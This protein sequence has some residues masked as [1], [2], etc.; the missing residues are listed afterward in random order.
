MPLLHICR[1]HSY[2]RILILCGVLALGATSQADEVAELCAIL[3]SDAPL[4]DRGVACRRLAVIGSTES[5]PVLATWL[6]DAELSHLARAALEAIPSPQVDSLFRQQ[7]STASGDQLIGIIDSIGN[8][9]DAAAVESLALL[10]PQSAGA[11]QAAV[12]A[13]LGAIASPES[14]EILLTLLENRANLQGDAAADATVVNAVADAA[15]RCADRFAVEGKTVEALQVYDAVRAAPV[16]PTLLAAATLSTIRIPGSKG[17]T[18]LNEQLVS[19][20]DDHFAVGLQA[21]RRMRASDVVG[22][23]ADALPNATPQ[24]AVMLLDALSDLGDTSALPAVREAA[25]SEN[26]GVKA[27]AIS[28]LGKV[29]DTSVLELLLAASGSDNA[30]VASAAQRSLAE[31]HGEGV[32]QAIL[33][34]LQRTPAHQETLLRLIGARR[35]KALPVLWAAMKT[36]ELPV[37]MAA[38]DALGRTI[39]DADILPLVDVVLNTTGEEHAAA[40]AALTSACRRASDPDETVRQISARFAAAPLDLQRMRFDILKTIGGEEAL[41]QV[42]RGAMDPEEPIQDAATRALGEWPTPDVGPELLPLCHLLQI[43][44]FKIR[45]LR[46]YIR[47]FKQF[48]LPSEERL[49]MAREAFAL[50]TR[51]EDKVLILHALLSFQNRESMQFALEHIKDPGLEA[52]A[53]QVAIYISEQ[54][55]DKQAVIDAMRSILDS[56]AEETYAKQARDILAKNGALGQ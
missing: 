53:A 34:T 5:I 45:A 39:P 52:T 25:G 35:M 9:R 44:K 2:S 41:K 1:G 4:H 27:A 42:I 21:A 56:G 50:A 43:P 46:A 24:R 6:G 48:G 49:Q 23:L 31:L 32:D 16:S 33:D 11:T 51:P 17:L 55:S 7:L 10:L 29:G 26:A 36:T 40:I 18:L 20:N 13:A 12:L 28:A 47:V 38:L 30:V 19:S 3:Q 22:K 15:L 14:A 8:R 54:V 37:R